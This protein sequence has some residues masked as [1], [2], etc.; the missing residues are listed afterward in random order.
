MEHQ[1]TKPE[2]IR[3]L[4]QPV[5]K[6]YININKSVPYFMRN[7][8]LTCS[9]F[10]SSF[11]LIMFVKLFLIQKPKSSTNLK[12]NHRLQYHNFRFAGKNECNSS[13]DNFPV[14]QLSPRSIV[15]GIIIQR[16]NHLKAN[17]P[18]GPL[19]G[20]NYFWGNCQGKIIQEAAVRGTIIRV[21]I[22]LRGN[23]LS[24]NNL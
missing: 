3:K 9:S 22:S 16:R 12:N 10:L 11:S 21:A 6:F 1:T 24:T 19:S 8:L 5:H 13:S 15:R 18:R 7:F 14:W 20:G 2:Q 23:C 17:F 4:L